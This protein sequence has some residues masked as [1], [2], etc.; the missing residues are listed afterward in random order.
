MKPT[1]LFLKT[2]FT[3]IIAMA[4]T[5]ACAQ[6][7]TLKKPSSKVLVAL[8]SGKITGTIK[9]PKSIGAI[10]DFMSTVKTKTAVK[11]YK[12]LNGQLADMKPVTITTMSLADITRPDGADYVYTYEIQAVFPFNRPIDIV[13]DYG[14]YKFT[15]I[16][17]LSKADASEYATITDGDKIY[18]G[19]DFK[20][21][22]VAH[23]H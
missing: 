17:D 5:S 3:A 23:P 22:A 16:L 6:A 9:F 20:G 11:S 8:N 15:W 21:K 13:I 14:E 18:T 10:N 12:L 7:P 19:F 2:C 4:I 1:A